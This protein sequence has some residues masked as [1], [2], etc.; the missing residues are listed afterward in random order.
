MPFR[1]KVLPGST[2]TKLATSANTCVFKNT[3]TRLGCGLTHSPIATN[4]V[5]LV[6][7]DLG[8]IPKV[9]V[10]AMTENVVQGGMRGGGGGGTEP[11]D[12]WGWGEGGRGLGVSRA[13]AG[14][15]RA[16]MGSVQGDGPRWCLAAQDT[17]VG[18]IRQR[19]VTDI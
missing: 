6:L 16:T 5:E 11:A 1:L 15:G 19:P 7:P 18:A 3:G 14:V 13:A 8:N 17:I 4:R 12:L 2:V 10:L 9:S